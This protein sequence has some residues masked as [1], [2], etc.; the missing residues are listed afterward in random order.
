M[1][2]NRNT[3]QDVQIAEIKNDVSW[4]KRTFERFYNNEFKHL[5]RL[6]E[7]VICTVIIGTLLSIAISILLN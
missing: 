6:V 3:K 1:K 4:I 2:N 5:Q 7:W